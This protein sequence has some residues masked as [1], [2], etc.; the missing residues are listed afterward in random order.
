MSFVEHK[1]GRKARPLFA[2]WGRMATKGNTLFLKSSLRF[3][4]SKIIFLPGENMVSL[5]NRQN[6]QSGKWPCSDG[7]FK[8][9]LS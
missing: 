9:I 5:T 4:C 3:L 2:T 1:T 7:F 6:L 8:Q